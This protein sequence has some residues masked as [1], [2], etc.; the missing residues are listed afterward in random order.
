M[1]NMMAIGLAAALLSVPGTAPASGVRTTFHGD[2]IM[3]YSDVANNQIPNQDA[4]HLRIDEADLGMLHQI[5]DRTTAYFR[6]AMSPG[7]F[8][9]SEAWLKFEGL[10]WEGAVTI[11]KFYRPLGASIPLSNLSFPALTLH[12][13]PELGI[14]VSVFRD[15]IG[16]EVGYVNGYLLSPLASSARIAGT[17]VI[18]NSNSTILD[19]KRDWYGRLYVVRGE[20]WG[21]L[22]MGMTYLGGRLPPEEIDALNPGGALNLFLFNTTNFE[23]D[24]QHLS[25]DADYQT[26]PWRVYGEYAHARDGRL[27]RSMYSIAGSYSFYPRIGAVTTTLGFDKLD[28]H[29]QVIRLRNPMSWDRERTSFTVAWW[30]T[31][32]ISV[33]ME[34]DLNKENVLQTGGGKIDNDAFTLQTIFYF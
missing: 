20:D 14:K 19:N 6:I 8:S 7:S 24:R 10:P 25:F 17:P 21:S 3:S 5:N 2:V 13:Y 28:I 9:L 1:L 34:F 26:G 15:P 33:Q 12:S 23:D 16:F 18:S 29:D 32:S 22:T 31:E 4:E 11:G 27:Q 30:P